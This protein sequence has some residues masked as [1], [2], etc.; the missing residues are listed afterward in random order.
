MNYIIDDLDKMA[1]LFATAIAITGALAQTNCTGSSYVPG[2]VNFTLECYNAIQNCVSKF[3]ANASLVDCNDGQGNI[4]MQQQASL[5]ST[6]PNSDI[7]I[8]FQDILELC[9]LSGSTSGTWGYSDNQWYW[10]AAEPACY[11]DST[12]DVVPTRPA[13]FCIQDR[14]SSL[15][16]CYPQPKSIASSANKFKVLKTSGSTPNGFNSSARGWNTYGIQ[17]LSNGSEV[18]PSFVGSSGLNYLQ[19]FVKTQCGVLAQSGFQ[20]AGY[21]YCSLDSGWQTQ[22]TDEYGRIVYDST[23]FNLPQLA[24]WLHG[25]GLKL[26]VYV[27]PGVPCSAANKTIK[28]TNISINDALNGNNDQL[29]CSWNFSKDGVQEWHDSVVAQWASWGVDMIKLDFLTPGSPQNGANLDCDSSDA[30]H[31][32]LNAIKASGRHMRLDLSWKLCRNETWL[33]IWSQLGDSMRID[34]DLDNYGYNTFVAWATAQRAIDNYR[35]YI[36]LQAQRN[37]PLTT[38][39]DMDNLFTANAENLTGVP[40]L[41]RITIMNHWL[42][43]GA[44]LILGGD[45]TAIDSLGYQLLTS[46]ESIAAADFFSQYPMQPRNPSTGDNL[47]QQLQAWIAGPSDDSIAYVLLVNYGPDQGQGGFGTQLKGIQDV[48]VSLE[49]LGISGS[50][51]HATDLWNGTAT[52]ITDSY[53]VALDEGASQLLRLTT[54]S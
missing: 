7:V 27:V 53:T 54:A 39:P 15:P 48:T 34:Q 11:V 51:W 36:G 23:R 33:P 21:V 1:R 10:T 26:G 46:A 32:Y 22:T 49:D 47:A 42:G 18:V 8:A 30:A 12:T 50:S 52:K 31:A 6:S 5:T 3:E 9:I 35:Q 37:V 16:D 41:Q 20:Q 43:A 13:P 38:Y 17:A 28:G 29:Y 4:Y 45:L 44:N 24:S 40:D 14:D 2:S 25:Q 19:E